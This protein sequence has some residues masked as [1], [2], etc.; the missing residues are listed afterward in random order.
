M[1]RTEREGYVRVRG[2]RL[3][4]RRFGIRGRPAVLAL[5]GGPGLAHDYLTPLADLAVAGYE[6]VL[7]DQLGCGR[8]E[9]PSS[10]RDYTIGAAAEDADEVR[11]RLG[12]GRVH[13]FG[14][15]YGG[16]LALET[17]LRHPE[18]LRSLIVSSGFAS[19]ETLWRGLRLR[20]SQLSPQD[21]TAY[22]REDRTGSSTPE[23]VRAVEEFRRRF[24]THL[25]NVPY[26]LWTLF[27]R[28]NRKVSVAMG[29]SA[30]N[31]VENGFRTGTMAGWDVTGRLRRLRMPVLVTSGQFDHVVPECAR[32]IHR[33]IPHSRLIV[34]KG[35]G[36]L[37]FFEHRDQY[38]TVLRRFLDR[39][40]TPPRRPGVKAG[41]SEPRRRAASP[42]SP[43]DRRTNRRLLPRG[44]AD[45]SRS[46]GPTATP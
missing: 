17:A 4:Y 33:G 31:L 12:L 6:V 46:R 25:D 26:E 18:G 42:R 45:R 15:S 44:T 13:L 8:S 7:Y 28:A 20:V 34:R 24:M 36:H 40:T 27:P 38:I 3:F 41:G 32:E 22:L 39:A 43:R 9:R 29:F 35:E 10:Y 1:A 5:H 11:R 23:S 2:K 16:A 14:H 21:R 37:P 30:L 19:L